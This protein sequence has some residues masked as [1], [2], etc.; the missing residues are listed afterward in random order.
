MSRTKGD[1]LVIARSWLT[2][3]LVAVACAAAE[4]PPGV[5]S[6][7][8]AAEP[9]RAQFDAAAGRVRAIFLAAPT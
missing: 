8:A 4:P 5:V 6:L 3:S 1:A 9:L 7:D 2:L